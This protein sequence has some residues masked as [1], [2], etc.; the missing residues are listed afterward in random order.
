MSN[1]VIF[2]LLSCFLITLFCGLVYASV[3]QSLRLSAD[4]PQIQISQD[5]VNSLN[6]GADP[7]QLSASNLDLRKSLSPFVVIYDK[8]GKAVAS[9]GVIDGKPP[10]LPQG[11]FDFVSKH[12]EKRLSWQVEK[13]VR[14]AS[15]VVKYKNGFVLVARSL[16]EVEVREDIVLKFAVIAWILGI[17]ATSLAFFISG[18]KLKIS[19]IRFPK[20]FL[21][22]LPKRAKK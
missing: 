14:M 13:G 4:D 17:G 15:V 16:K 9:S 6:Q 11:V 7:R 2:W 10:V 12:G 18:K 1:K 3:Q 20:K 22:K 21:T 19:S 5:V 8:S